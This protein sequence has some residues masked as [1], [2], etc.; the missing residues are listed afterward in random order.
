LLNFIV[1]LACLNYNRLKLTIFNK[2]ITLASTIIVKTAF[3]GSGEQ[4]LEEQNAISN[5]M[6]TEDRSKISDPEKERSVS[7]AQK[8]STSNDSTVSLNK[9]EVRE[10]LVRG[11]F[12]LGPR[13]YEPNSEKNVYPDSPMAVGS[14]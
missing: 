8:E 13:T 9:T 11:P 6:Q 12:G 4:N 7:P 3:E 10:E 2:P 1:L 5:H 14:I